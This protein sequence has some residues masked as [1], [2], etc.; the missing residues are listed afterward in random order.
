M[1]CVFC[2]TD[3]ELCQNSH[4]NVIDSHHVRMSNNNG[5]SLLVIATANIP[6]GDNGAPAVGFTQQHKNPGNNM[7]KHK[8]SR[9]VL[10]EL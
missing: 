9:I 3:S 6:Q 2:V 8:Q 4:V 1:I 7:H 10:H 5:D